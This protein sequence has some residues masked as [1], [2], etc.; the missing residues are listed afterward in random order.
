MKKVLFFLCLVTAFIS[1][2]SDDDSGKQVQSLTPPSWI[3][4]EWRYTVVLEN[5]N[6]TLTDNG[7]NFL[8]E[9]VCEVFTTNT[10]CFKSTYA[11]ESGV[12]FTEYIKN[13]SEYKFSYTRGNK[14]EQY[15]FSRIDKDRIK[16]LSGVDYNNA[17]LEKL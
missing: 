7:Y 9:D 4:G 8:S 15:Y 14:T 1:C 2:S 13:D 5:N 3:I 16:Q 6:I 11:Q 12:Y 17:V 10:L